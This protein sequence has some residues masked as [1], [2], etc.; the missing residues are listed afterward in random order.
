MHGAKTGCVD[1]SKVDLLATGPS[2]KEERMLSVDDGDSQRLLP[3]P[4]NLFAFPLE[5][6]FSGTRYS[7]S[8]ITAIQGRKTTPWSVSLRPGA[9]TWHQ[10]TKKVAHSDDN[11]AEI[12]SKTTQINEHSDSSSRPVLASGGRWYVLLDAAKACGTQP[13]NIS[14]YAADFVAISYYKIFGYPTGLGALLIRRDALKGLRKVY[15]SGGTVLASTAEDRFH[16]LR[17]GPSGLEDGTLSFLSIPAVLRGFESWDLHG[18]F[19]A[20][21]T[22]AHTAATRF[23][24][25]LLSLR[26]GN[27]APVAAVYGQWSEFDKDKPPHTEYLI[28]N[29]RQG[30]V[31]ATST[32]IISG[33][34]PTVTFNLLD[35]RGLWV[36]HKQVQRISSL[37]G[38]FLRSGVMCNPGGCG[39][40]LGVDARDAQE[41]YDAGHVCWDDKDILNGKPTGAVRASFGWASTTSDADAIIEV[42]KRHFVEEQPVKVVEKNNKLQNV[43]GGDSK[44][45]SHFSITTTSITAG[46]DDSGLLKHKDSVVCSMRQLHVYSLTVYPIKSAG[47]FSPRS[48]SMG[49]TGLLYDRH[50]AVIDAEGNILTQKRCPTLATLKPIIDLED[51]VMRIS[52]PCAELLPPLVIPL[53]SSS[54][55][56]LEG[57][58]SITNTHQWQKESDS[59]SK[60]ND[61]DTPAGTLVHTSHR[62]VSSEQ[63][64]VKV[65]ARGVP[66]CATTQPR[67]IT[68]DSILGES[69]MDASQWLSKVLGIPC[70][71]VEHSSDTPKKQ[72][73]RSSTEMPGPDRGFSND[74]QLLMVT[75]ASIKALQRKCSSSGLDKEPLGTF[76]A[77]FRPNIVIEDKLVEDFSS[78]CFSSDTS[79]EEVFHDAVETINN[80][81]S[82]SNEGGVVVLSGVPCSTTTTV[83]AYEEESWKSV[84]I[85]ELDELIVAGGCP[86]CEF[87]CSD[88]NT[89]MKMGK[90]PLLTLARERRGAGKRR[91]CFGVLL[92]RKEGNSGSEESDRNSYSGGVWER[93]IAVKMPV[94]CW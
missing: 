94:H 22:A 30:E 90:D 66:A 15:F 33:Q 54:S 84:K 67:K 88:P 93:R 11:I 19:S 21:L 38:I 31:V 63:V 6:N 72:K 26:H 61:V 35:S 4:A 56:P 65:C 73:R 13:P 5:S 76:I 8:L 46:E 82:T 58:E 43:G 47:G 20:A 68:N 51:G 45:F 1:A 91:L 37:E 28:K 3:G 92:N 16:A 36:G 27:G 9:V 86:R 71:L 53:V 41:W 32:N 74:A 89:G 42:I 79:E 64:E 39:T 60:Q 81:S 44:S 83:V 12:N 52:A 62:H 10:Q 77:R 48:W 70:R 18:S 87:I 25:A 34:G 80:N 14:K 29:N 78:C 55:R 23:A 50:W 59:E 85:G 69:S 24:G 49:P 17:S 7:E 2:E 40:A 57:I 75:M